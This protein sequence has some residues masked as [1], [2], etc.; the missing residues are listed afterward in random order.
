MKSANI[1]LPLMPFA[2]QLIMAQS[3]IRPSPLVTGTPQEGTAKF[4]RTLPPGYVPSTLKQMC[5][6]ST[7]IVEG[8]VRSS[9][10][11]R[12]LSPNNLETDSIIT[13]TRS[14]KGSAANA[15][16]SVSQPG[17]TIGK[18]TLSPAQYNIM[19][20][21][22]KYL[23]FLKEDDR[24]NIPQMSGVKRYIVTGA[25]SGLFLLN[26][27]KMQVI[28]DSPDALRKTYEG[29]SEEEII[30]KVMEVMDPKFVP[31]PPQLG[32]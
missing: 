11:P 18:L 6:M 28:A 22:E 7:L 1:W 5:D 30:A 32:R 26:D 24:P 10:L 23:L 29:L 21:G 3:G 9:L 19:R 31:P 4:Y 14:L 15:D 16:I 27:G 17:G 8:T 25:W 20:P 12:Q 2:M 13:V